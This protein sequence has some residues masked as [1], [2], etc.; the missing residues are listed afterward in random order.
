MQNALNP[1]PTRF[2]LTAWP[3]LFLLL[4]AVVPGAGCTISYGEATF[5]VVEGVGEIE[6][7]GAFANA[8]IRLVDADGNR[9]ARGNRDVSPMNDP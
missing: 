6:V 1:S 4:L 3:L 7:I 2:S 5:Q 9:V 8:D